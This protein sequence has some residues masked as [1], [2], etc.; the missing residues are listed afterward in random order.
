MDTNSGEW[1]MTEIDLVCG[2]MVGKGKP[3]HTLQYH[4]N[5]YSFCTEKC[6]TAFDDNPQKYLDL[7]ETGIVE[8]RKAGIVGAGQVGATFAVALITSGLMS[9]SP[10]QDLK[11]YGSSCVNI[12][13]FNL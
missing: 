6:K 2:T 3:N 13:D 11:N 12:N 7:L 4:G 5:I 8:T 9:G 1:T 10:L